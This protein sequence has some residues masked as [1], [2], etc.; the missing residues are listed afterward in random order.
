MRGYNMAEW[1]DAERRAV[2]ADLIAC[3]IRQKCK[4]LRDRQKV[5]REMLAE[6]SPEMQ[7]LVKQAMGR[8]AR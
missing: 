8:R 2:N 7:E 3:R 6:L 4:G 1:P 5:A